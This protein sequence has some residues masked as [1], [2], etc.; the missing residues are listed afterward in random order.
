MRSHLCVTSRDHVTNTCAR[1]VN[2]EGTAQRHIAAS[3]KGF[4]SFYIEHLPEID[5]GMLDLRHDD[6]WEYYTQGIPEDCGFGFSLAFIDCGCDYSKF[7]LV[8]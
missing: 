8:S 5:C 2:R 4:V 6:V 1:A 3:Y 7:E